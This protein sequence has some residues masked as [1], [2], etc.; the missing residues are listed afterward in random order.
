MHS[1]IWYKNEGLERKQAVLN[2]RYCLATTLIFALTNEI[3]RSVF[4][5][6]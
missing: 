2:T 3:D 1:A 4:D 6:F 5:H